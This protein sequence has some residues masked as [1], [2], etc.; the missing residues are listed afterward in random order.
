M[1]KVCLQSGHKSMTS[2]STGAPLER[3][4]T[5]AIVPKISAILQS[6]G[7]EVYE[8]DAFA[9]NDPKVTGTD[10]NLFLAIHYDADIYNDRGGFVD[11]PDPT[12]DAATAESTRIANAIREY[13]FR[14][15]GV[16]NKAMRSNANTKFYYMWQ[17]LSAKTPCVILEAGVGNRKPEDFTTLQTNIDSTAKI[18]ANAILSAFQVDTPKIEELE[19]EIDELRASRDSWKR[20]FKELEEKYA[21]EVQSKTEMI[22]MLQKSGSELTLQLVTT[23]QMLTD[24]QTQVKSLTEVRTALEDQIADSQIKIQVLDVKILKLEAKVKNGLSSYSRLELFQAL[25]LRR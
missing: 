24:A 6:N 25:F 4:W 14:E 15:S 22:E 23:S 12:V 5:T 7:F 16:P 2:G 19:K 8:T 18:I 3:A 10:W 17:Y 11:I 13:Y 1:F 21:A 9:Q 20:Q